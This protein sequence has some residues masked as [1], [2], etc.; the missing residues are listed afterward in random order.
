MYGESL[1]LNKSIDLY[2]LHVYICIDRNKCTKWRATLALNFARIL[3]KQCAYCHIHTL[4]S[5]CIK[6]DALSGKLVPAYHYHAAVYTQW[7]TDWSKIT[8]TSK[9]FCKNNVFRGVGTGNLFFCLWDVLLQFS[10]LTL[11][12]CIFSYVYVGYFVPRSFRPRHCR[13]VGFD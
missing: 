3:K 2:A 5:I 10:M 7:L 1:I 12:S 8:S 6:I 11:E 13:R 9:Y 4:L